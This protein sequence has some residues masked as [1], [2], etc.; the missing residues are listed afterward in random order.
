MN[1]DP[2]DDLY[3]EGLAWACEPLVSH[4]ALLEKAPVDAEHGFIAFDYL[5]ALMDGQNEEY[6]GRDVLPDIWRFI[7]DSLPEEEA[8]NAGLTAFLRSDLAG[9]ERI[10]RTIAG[11]SSAYATEAIFD[12][13]NLLTMR[14]DAE[15]ARE[16]Y[17]RAI[18][19]DHPHITPMA[20]G[21]LG[22][23]LAQQGDTEGA[24]VAFERAVDTGHPEA[25]PPASERLRHLNR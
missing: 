6:Q 25:A 20:A 2:S 23:A 15:G 11:R 22:N 4:V 16:A 14:G 7:V 12:L 13:G 5:V 17:Q 24:R 19:A 9:A 1:L 8:M 10:W 21:Y 18:D 3:S